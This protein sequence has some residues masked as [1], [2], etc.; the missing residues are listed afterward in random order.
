MILCLAKIELLLIKSILCCS[1]DSLHQFRD[2]WSFFD[3]EAT[4]YIDSTDLLSL[5]KHIQPPLGLGAEGTPIDLYRF[6]K[7]ISIPVHEGGKLHF[8]EVLFALVQNVIGTEIP[9]SQLKKDLQKK[10]IKHLPSLRREEELMN[11]DV[12]MTRM[13]EETSCAPPDGGTTRTTNEAG[14]DA[15]QETNDDP[16]QVRNED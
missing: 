2:A 13:K 15:E 4:R 8:S 9:S 10:M 7:T 5:L 1:E 3:P 6:V 12:Y 14:V 11:V 16:K